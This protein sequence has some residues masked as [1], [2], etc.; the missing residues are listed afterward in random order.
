MWYNSLWAV[1]VADVPRDRSLPIFATPMPD[2]EFTGRWRTID[3]VIDAE[4]IASRSVSTEGVMVEHGQLLCSDLEAFGEFR[5]WESLD[6]LADFVFWGEEAVGVAAVFQAA[7]LGERE[8]GW[9][10]LPIEEIDQHAQ[11]VQN[12]IEKNGLNVGVDYRPH[13]NLEKLN[14]QIRENDLEAG[15]VLLGQAKTCGFSNRWGDGIFEVV[16]DF[17]STG[18]L[19]RIRLDVGS[20]KTQTLMRAVRVRRQGAIVSRKILDERQPIRFAE[21]L[22]PSRP[23]DSGWF[24]SAGTENDDYMSDA[25]NLAVV[26]IQAILEMDGAVRGILG[27][28]VGSVF[29]RGESGFVAEDV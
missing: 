29:Q 8:Y 6:G 27:A 25:E 3:I 15:Q 7:K 28:P 5:M 23:E 1:A 17:D 26:S 22:E 13:C 24:F 10:D 21:R 14:R 11:A 9:K 2:G 18:R 12:H 4:A 19:I 20:E 16:R